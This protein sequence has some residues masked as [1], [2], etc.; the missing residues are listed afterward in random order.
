MPCEIALTDCLSV[1]TLVK[2]GQCAPG[3]VLPLIERAAS[4]LQRAVGGRLLRSPGEAAKALLAAA[5]CEAAESPG[6]ARLDCTYA[7][8]FTPARVD[9]VYIV[10]VGGRGAWRVKVARAKRSLA[11]L[12]RQERDA[13]YLRAARARRRRLFAHLRV[14]EVRRVELG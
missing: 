3:Y 14:E 11:R 13:A 9:Y 7:C 12:A 6:P 1:V 5:L 4:L 2:E 10:V 8:A